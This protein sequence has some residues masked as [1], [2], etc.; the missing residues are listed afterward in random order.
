MPKPNKI[1]ENTPAIAILRRSTEDQEN[2]IETQRRSIQMHC[3]L[4]DITIEVEHYFEETDSGSTPFFDRSQTA[5][6]IAAAHKGGIHLIVFAFLDRFS[7]DVIDGLGS[8]E[9]LRDSAGIHCRFADMGD[10][11]TQDPMGECQVSFALIMARF[12]RRRLLERQRRTIATR[13][14]QGLAV[15]PPPFGHR[16]KSEDGNT[17]DHKVLIPDEREQRI[18]RFITA[19]HADGLGDRAIT[20]ELNLRMTSHNDWHPRGGAHKEWARGSVRSIIAR[21]SED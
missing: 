7:R 12:E 21:I 18:L 14:E 8:I 16:R 5:P 4:H 13:R 17:P 19:L 10:T 1:S 6:A 2:S 20:S 15:G 11:D 3:K 9:K